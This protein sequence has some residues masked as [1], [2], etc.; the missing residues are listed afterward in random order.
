MRIIYFGNGIRG[1]KCLEELIRAKEEIVA[2]IGHPGNKSDVIKLAENL[3]IPFFQPVRVNAPEFV[4]TLRKIEGE[5]FILSGYNQ[6]LKSE[7]IHLPK[8]GCIN[9]HGGKLPDYRGVAP[10]NWQIINGEKEGGC[11]ILYVDEGID[12]GDI[13]IQKQY[14]I[15]CKDTSR[16][17]INKQLLLFPRMLLSVIE[18]MKKGEVRGIPQDKEKGMYYRRRYPHDGL[19]KWGVMSSIEVYNLIRAL[20]DPY[21]NAFTFLKGRKVMIKKAKE[22]DPPTCGVP[23]RLSIK[24]SEGVVVGC[25]DK[26]IMILEVAFEDDQTIYKPQEIFNVGVEFT[27]L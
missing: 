10:I 3:S 5:L 7:L 11:C 15:S 8:R 23:G 26:G 24:K 12:T 19:I 13:I 21:P 27:E 9:L 4:N 6:I 16:D 18:R 22:I 2:V 17:I 14:E 1:L 20:V 25:K